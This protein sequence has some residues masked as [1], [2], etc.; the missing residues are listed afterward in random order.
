MPSSPKYFLYS[1]PIGLEARIPRYLKTDLIR[2]SLPEAYIFRCLKTNPI[3]P[4]LPE[5]RIL[6]YLKTNLVRFSL[7]YNFDTEH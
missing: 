1:L 2:P 6:I 3:R 4:S 7:L 5:A